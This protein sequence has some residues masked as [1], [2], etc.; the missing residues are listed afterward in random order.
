MQK[1]KIFFDSMSSEEKE[2]Y[3]ERVRMLKL[4]RRL[5]EQGEIIRE[6]ERR[7]RR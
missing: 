3:N 7:T 4:D 5:E 6:L 1:E 2:K